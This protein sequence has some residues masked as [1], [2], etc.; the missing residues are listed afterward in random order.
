MADF[1][2]VAPCSIV[3]FTDVSEV[4]ASIIQTTRLYNPE[5]SHLHTRRRENL[6]SVL[7]EIGCVD[8]SYIHLDQDEVQRRTVL[9]SNEP[10]SFFKVIDFL[11]V[12]MTV[13][14]LR[15]LLHD[16]SSVSKDAVNSDNLN[17]FLVPLSNRVSNNLSL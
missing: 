13:R 16:V 1:W 10:Y 17:C 3:D 14:F 15:T 4:L 12:L 11:T 8:E 5:D 9:N 6:K 7:K 2:V